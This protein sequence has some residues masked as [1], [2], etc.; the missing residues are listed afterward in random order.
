MLKYFPESAQK[1]LRIMRM[2]AEVPLY[3]RLP[4]PM[5]VSMHIDPSN[6][7]NFRCVFCPT[8]DRELLLSVNRFTG[9]MSFDLFRKIIDDCRDMVQRCDRRLVQLHL[10]KDGEPLLN[11]RFVA[12]A[13]YAKEKN[14]ARN[15][16]TATNGSLLTE[17]I[18]LGLIRSGIDTIRIS[19]ERCDD[20]GYKKITRTYS[21]FEGLRKK[22]AFLYREKTKQASPLRILVKINDA[23][24]SREE[25]KKFVH[26]FRPIC[27]GI[28]I[29]ALMGWS[30]SEKKDFT[31]G[32]P[33]ST[34]M[35]GVTPLRDRNVCPEPFSKLAVNPD[36]SV[37]VCCVDWTYATV[38]GDAT[39]RNILDIWQGEPL[40]RF[41]MTHLKGERSALPACASCHYIRGFPAS[42]SLD[43]HAAILLKTY[44]PSTPGEG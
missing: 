33:V 27:D 44:S 19:I 39:K 25:R 9:T 21:D 31:L 28:K 30:A 26:I 40:Q 36:G 3:K 11:D 1:F 4:L 41:R 16:S 14:I 20:E 6:V 34:A 15:V 10:Y 13:A 29:D 17:E 2:R 12:M 18:S 38:V 7:C 37:S 43:K 23:N 22:I 24:L 8:G 5:P 35:D 32:A 42:E